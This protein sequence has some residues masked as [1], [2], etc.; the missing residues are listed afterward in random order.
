MRF[1]ETSVIIYHMK[2]R[3]EPDDLRNPRHYCKH[4]KTHK[5]LC[6]FTWYGDAPGI[7]I[8]SDTS[9]SSYR[10]WIPGLINNV[11]A[12]ND[13]IFSSKLCYVIFWNKWA[14]Y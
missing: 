8:S 7:L 5:C 12:R 11:V 14:K 10:W 6:T 13:I 3:N 1:T 2:R 4:L 9:K